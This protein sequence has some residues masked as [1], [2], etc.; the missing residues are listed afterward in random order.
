V[1]FGRAT[2]CTHL[3]NIINKQ[4]GKARHRRFAAPLYRKSAKISLWKKIRESVTASVSP[5]DDN[6]LDLA[7]CINEKGPEPTSN[8]RRFQGLPTL[9]MRR[10][11]GH[12]VPCYPRQVTRVL[13]C[14]SPPLPL[15]PIRASWAETQHPPP[16][17]IPLPQVNYTSGTSL[18]KTSIRPPNLDQWSRFWHKMT[19]ESISGLTAL[20]YE[21]R[22]LS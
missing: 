5:S 20:L 9:I 4:K 7:E 14:H 16:E 21:V 2:Q 6:L 19:V 12:R 22:Q 1:G 3:L 18:G 11:H 8:S 15:P 13:R 10:E 17:D